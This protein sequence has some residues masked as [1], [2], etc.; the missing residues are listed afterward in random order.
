MIQ[1]KLNFTNI[2]I[3]SLLHNTQQ[4]TVFNS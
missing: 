4:L 1:V 3:S 2:T